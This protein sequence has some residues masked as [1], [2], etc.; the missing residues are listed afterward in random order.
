MKS[1]KKPHLSASLIASRHEK[2]IVDNTVSF[3][4]FGEVEKTKASKLPAEDFSLKSH[5]R[6]PASCRYTIDKV[7]LPRIQKATRKKMKK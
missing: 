1:K 4:L 7:V 2:T 6:S 5:K 3:E